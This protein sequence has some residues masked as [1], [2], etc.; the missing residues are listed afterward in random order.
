MEPLLAIEDVQVSFERESGGIA[1]LNGVDLSVQPGES[2]GIVSESGAGKT[3]L[4][5]TILNLLQAPWTVHRG[6]VRFDGEDLLAKQE[7]ELRRIRGV[8]IALTSPE[9]RKQLNPLV[10]IGDQL[11]HGIRAHRKISR[12]EALG[13]AVEA[14]ESV[15]I[16]T[17]ICVCAPSRMSSRAACASVSSS[18]WR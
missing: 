2:I 6:S 8:K 1:V 17:R 12:K 7:E 11:A 10:R 16:P 13:L 18:P 15:G 9:P 5:R 14:Q 4:V 3:V